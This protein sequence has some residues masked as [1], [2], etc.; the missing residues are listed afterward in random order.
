MTD[1]ELYG[2]DV[3]YAHGVKAAGERIEQLE[4]QLAELRTALGNA[5]VSLQGAHVMLAG[6]CTADDPCD[7]CIGLERSKL[8]V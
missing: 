6:D 7:G 2:Y 8:P 1:D 3:G 5:R 4:R